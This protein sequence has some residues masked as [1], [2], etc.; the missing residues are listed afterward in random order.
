M[1]KRALVLSHAGGL[2]FTAQLLLTVHQ[3]LAID[4]SF[5]NHGYASI[6]SFIFHAVCFF[7]G[8]GFS[9]IQ[10]SDVPL[11]F[12][13]GRISSNWFSSP[14]FFLFKTFKRPEP[15]ALVSSAEFQ[16]RLLV[17]TDFRGRRFSRGVPRCASCF[18]ILHLDA[19]DMPVSCWLS[20]QMLQSLTI[21]NLI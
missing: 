9:F 6:A 8:P 15:S 7:L 17:C 4:L 11:L 5:L 3:G 1:I 10:T 18:C 13:F 14:R 2:N 21:C 20:V 12:R 19:D 16:D